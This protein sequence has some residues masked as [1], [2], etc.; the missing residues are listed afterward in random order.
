MIKAEIIGN[1]G[2]APEKK[3]FND[4]ESWEFGVAIDEGKNKDGTPKTTWVRV[5]IECGER[6]D[7]LMNYVKPGA[8]VAA[9]GKLK[10]R[11]AEGGKEPWLTLYAPVE[12]FQFVGFGGGNKERVVQKTEQTGNAAP[13]DF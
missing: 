11:S 13:L 12:L 3:T 1:V 9:T 10:A 6:A 7:K 8:K 5:N 2:K 4:R